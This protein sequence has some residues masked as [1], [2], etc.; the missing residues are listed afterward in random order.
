MIRRHI[1]HFGFWVL[2][3]SLSVSCS[4]RSLQTRKIASIA[5]GCIAPTQTLLNLISEDPEFLTLRSDFAK[6]GVFFEP[7]AGEPSQTNLAS[8]TRML[9][10]SWRRSGVQIT[11][12]RELG[13][14]TDSSVSR[15]TLNDGRVFSIKSS[16]RDF[17][18][19]YANPQFRDETYRANDKMLFLKAVGEASGTFGV[20][21]RVGKQDS[22]EVFEYSAGVS[23]ESLINNPEIPEQVR[24]FVEKR[25]QA[26]LQEIASAL[27]KKPVIGGV[28]VVV[29]ERPHFDLF[30]ASVNNQNPFVFYLHTGNWVV[31]P[32]TLSLTV[33]DPL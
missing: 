2:L 24:R 6:N 3:S 12:I 23:L 16:S 4:S 15:I 11:E 32:H 19:P 30:L 33:I 28:Q 7:Y 26:A 13:K 5:S 9:P 1:F 20:I 14:G 22:L 21:T 10:Y 31:N 17:Q 27:E 29:G 8:M 25:F 18:T